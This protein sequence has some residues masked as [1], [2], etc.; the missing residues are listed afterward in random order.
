LARIAETLKPGEW[1]WAPSV[2][3]AAPMLVYVN[4]S[5]QR[6]TVYRNGVRIGVRG[7]QIICVSVAMGP[8]LERKGIHDD[9]DDEA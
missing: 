5:T 8:I 6:A 4:L 7:C 3:P 2:A 9:E 1:I